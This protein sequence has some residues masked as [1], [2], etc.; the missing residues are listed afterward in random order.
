MKKLT[1][2][3]AGLGIAAC[4]FAFNAAADDGLSYNYVEASY[5]DSEIDDLDI[6]GDGLALAGSVAIGDTMFLHAGYGTLDFD[7]GIDLDQKTIGLGAHTSISNNV[8]LIG[9]IGYVDAELD[10]PFGSADDDGYSVG[11]G[12]RGKIAEAFELEGGISYVDLDDSGDDT[13]FNLGGRYYFTESFALGAGI[14]IG[15]DVT[16][17]NLGVRLEF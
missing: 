15:D 2:I 13:T 10:T 4:A 17:W 11:V 1:V 16:T 14:G 6:D 9:T 12:L 7:R 5:V 8:D 3:K